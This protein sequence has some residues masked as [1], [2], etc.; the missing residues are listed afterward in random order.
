MGWRRD[1]RGERRLVD[2][3]ETRA[4]PGTG[5]DVDRFWADFAALLGKFAPSLADDVKADLYRF[6]DAALVE[7]RRRGVP[8]LTPGRPAPTAPIEA[9]GGSPTLG[10]APLEAGPTTVTAVAAP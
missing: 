8:T 3:L 5:L 10:L 7:N 9:A 2:F 6:A 4:L 1:L